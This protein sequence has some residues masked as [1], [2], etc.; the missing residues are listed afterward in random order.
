MLIGWCARA[1]MALACVYVAGCDGRRLEARLKV[2][3]SDTTLR[4]AAQGAAACV[5]VWG[6]VGASVV[7]CAPLVS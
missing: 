4:L 7:R 5:G 6:L 1:C 3:H 2:A